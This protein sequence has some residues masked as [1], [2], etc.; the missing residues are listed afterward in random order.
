[1]KTSRWA[2]VGMVLGALA[3]LVWQAPASWLAS[4]VQALSQERGQLPQPQGTAWHGSAQWVLALSPTHISEPTRPR[5]NSYAV[6]CLKKKK[7][8]KTKKNT[9]TRHISVHKIKTEH[10]THMLNHTV[11]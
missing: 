8:K 4:G 7:N 11:V 5:R 3:A 6:F 9:C 2:G 10:L 1:M